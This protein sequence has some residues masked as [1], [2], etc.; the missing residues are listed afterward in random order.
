MCGIVGFVS[1]HPEE[2]LIKNLTNSISHRGP[3]KIDYKIINVNNFY[4]HLGSSRLAINGLHDGDMPMQDLDENVLIY[5]GEIYNTDE[6]NLRNI[7]STSDTRILFEFLKVKSSNNLEMLNGM[8]A[9][10]FLNY[11]KNEL[12]ISR[13][14][15]GIKPLYYSHTNEYPIMFSSEMKTFT[16]IQNFKLHTSEK[17]I[18]EFI[19]TGENLSK[20]SLID[21]VRILEPG[22]YLKFNIGNSKSKLETSNYYHEVNESKLNGNPKNFEPIFLDVLKDQLNADVPVDILL[23]GGIDSSI[24]AIG[25]KKLLNLDVNAYNLSYGNKAYDES[26]KASILANDLG[27]KLKTFKFTEDLNDQVINE[28]MSKLPEPIL[29][30]SIVGTYFLSKNVAKYTKSVVSGDGA[31]ELFTGYSWHKLYLI[32]DFL[33]S[34]TPMFPNKISKKIDSFSNDYVGINTKLN[35]LRLTKNISI[36]K[37]ILYIQNS[38]LL[39]LKEVNKLDILFERYLENIN[40][41]DFNDLRELDINSYMKNSILKKVDTASML[42]GLEVRPVYLDNRIADFALSLNITKNINIFESKKILRDFLR[43]HNKK[44]SK[45]PK[46]GFPHDF[47]KWSFDIAM[48][49]LKNE[50]KNIEIV[51]KFIETSSN[52][53]LNNYQIS[54]GIWKLYCTFK[55]IDLNGIRVK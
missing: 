3:D 24:I 33:L 26:D 43:N 55:W 18:E 37:R 6:I 49:Y 9:F 45:F 44:L 30:P 17:D 53:N 31:D 19:Y 52:K 35:Y 48:P 50:W 1:D 10:A 12:L 34:S 13:D 16:L 42:N 11:K 54:R 15:Y 36:L 21:K 51:S 27:I 40:L 8:F 14:R 20:G 38:I 29:D 32:P 39:D 7:D 4:L 25:A 47:S 23:S 28:L 5:N 41:T 2:E 46:H 22:K